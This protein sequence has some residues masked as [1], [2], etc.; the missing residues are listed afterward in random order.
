MR[1]GDVQLVVPVGIQEAY[2][3]AVQPHLVNF[4][5]FLGDVRL[6]LVGGGGD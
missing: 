1:E 5:S 6:F 4:E 3:D 2:P